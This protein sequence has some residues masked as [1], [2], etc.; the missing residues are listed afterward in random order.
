M[1]MEVCLV[2]CMQVGNTV[3][4]SGDDD[5]GGDCK[6]GANADM[7]DHVTTKQHTSY[8]NSMCMFRLGHVPRQ[9]MPWRGSCNPQP[10][11]FECGPSTPLRTANQSDRQ[12]CPKFVNGGAFCQPLRCVVHSDTCKHTRQASKLAN[13]PII[14]TSER[15]HVDYCTCLHFS[16]CGW[17]QSQCF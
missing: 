6:V 12:A 8:P 1:C 3:V 16:R 5:G 9:C 13:E 2:V 15:N 7:S 4:R 17:T 10:C 14:S 11:D